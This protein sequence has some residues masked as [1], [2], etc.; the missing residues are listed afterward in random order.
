MFGNYN[1]CIAYGTWCIKIKCYVNLFILQFVYWISCR[2]HVGRILPKLPAPQKELSRPDINLHSRENLIRARAQARS[3]T[4]RHTHSHKHTN[5]TESVRRNHYTRNY[6]RSALPHI[7][8][9]PLIRPLPHI[10]ICKFV[11]ETFTRM[12]MIW[13][14]QSIDSVQRKIK[15][16]ICALLGF[17]AA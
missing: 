13:D 1:Q 14:N 16:E 7:Y 5:N 11:S 3:H 12:Y 4:D 17:L 9:V 10:L 15:S 2:P 6:K 8:I